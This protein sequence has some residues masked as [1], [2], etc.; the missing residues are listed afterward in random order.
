MLL[1]VHVMQTPRFSANNPFKDI[2]QTHV[3][4]ALLLFLIL[5]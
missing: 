5:T 1:D 3:K 2:A 4:V